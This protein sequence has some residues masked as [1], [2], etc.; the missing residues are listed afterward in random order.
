MKFVSPNGAIIAR[1]SAGL[2]GSVSFLVLA[3]VSSAFA[4]QA[5]PVQPIAAPT[6]NAI[7]L[8][9]TPANEGAV[10]PA[11][12]AQ[13]IQQLPESVL[14]TGSLIHGAPAIGVPVTSFSND[15]FKQ[16]GALTIGNLLGTVAAVYEL[17]QNDVTAGGGFLARGQDVNIRNLTLHG[18]RQLL[19]I[20]GIQ[21]PQQGRGG[22]Q[23]DPSII[24]QLAVDHVDLLVD[25]ASATYGSAA[26]TGVINVIL[27]RAYDGA[28]TQVQFGGSTDLGHYQEQATQLYGRTWDGGDITVSY[29]WYEQQ[30]TS[31][32]VR[33]YFTANY[34]TYAGVDNR[35]ALINSDPGIIS[36]GNP[37]APANTPTGFLATIGTICTNCYAIPKGQNGAGLTWAQILGNNP[38]STSF[39]GNERNLWLDAWTEPNQQRNAI[40]LTFD[41]KVVDSVSFFADAWYDNRQALMFGENS[42]NSISIAVPA[43]NPYYPA[44]APAGIKVNY[45]FNPEFLALGGN[46][47]PDRVSSQEIDG[48]F[49]AGFNINLPFDWIGKLYG[50]QTLNHNLDD[51]TNTINSNMVTAALGGTVAA[52]P[53]SV[54][55]P[56]A[57][58]SFTKPSSVPY[59]N[60]FCDPLAYTCNSPA[61]LNYLTGYSRNN[62][63]ETIDEF[64]LNADGPVIDLPTGTIKAAIGFVYQHWGFNSFSN[65]SNATTA[66][67]NNYTIQTG[68]R[69]IYSTF[70]QLDVPVIGK[71]FTLPLVEALTVEASV[72][73]D[74][75]SDFGP[76]TNPK[77]SADWTV[78]WGLTLRGSYGTSFRAPTFQ[79]EA[80]S[81]PG[82]INITANG[83]LAGSIQTCPTGAAT[84]LS[85]TAAASIAPTC[86][87]YLAGISS[88]FNP[89]IRANGG[90]LSAE[91]AIN[92]SVGFEFTPTYSFLKGLDV[93]ATYWY[94]AMNNIVENYYG[95]AGLQSGELDNP[96]WTHTFLFPGND[97][98][99]ASDVATL[100][101]GPKST[102][103]PAL[104][105]LIQF[106]ADTGNNNIGSQTVNGVDFSASYD[107]DAGDYGAW[108]TGISGTY[109][110]DNKSQGGPGQ[111][112]N[113][114]FHTPQ[115][116][117]STAL[118]TGGRMRYRA[119]L[120]WAN[121]DG[122]SL[123]GFLNFLP[124]FNSDTA[125]LPPSCFVQGNPV[126]ASYGPQFAQYTNQ[127]PR[128]S[129][130]VPG[131]YTFD[132][133]IGYN[134]G[135]KPENS[136]LK[137][138]NFQL[139]IINILDKQAPYAYQINPPGGA[140]IHAYYTTTPGQGFQPLGIDGRTI[141]ATI[142]KQW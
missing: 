91:T 52:V 123:T 118:D 68:R 25:G 41:Q 133:S 114:L 83:T 141:M 70:L 117:N 26:V 137:N 101:N 139:N 127:F 122:L 53:A 32:G 65:A 110:I 97:P 9:A 129:N 67:I 119:R 47:R 87:Q 66:A 49:D 33:P 6:T 19:L 135:E 100:L 20:D 136:Y 69:N 35:M 115:N 34:N 82:L 71:D 107:Y 131:L 28:I 43:N 116:S 56:F 5:L 64:G 86:A 112:V 54:A 50:A 106:I 81:G 75:Y 85:G 46:N 4:Q 126:C 3:S 92:R 42:G 44:G 79:E 22:C 14:V 29:E 132:L 96:I 51:T 138:V 23:T 80:P 103:S 58:G 105:P 142:S 24:P 134:T 11:Q 104:A 77:I 31:G 124:H 27:K 111:V 39:A 62:E 93:Q 72:R 74:H 16:T 95:V 2:L 99:F 40:T 61:T 113:S 1:K 108:N 38:S 125:V 121:D 63:T 84:A 76:T 45:D 89:A 8:A 59:L 48:R 88:G 60:L 98:H 30:H 10:A 102:L 120:G 78:G 37:A 13:A 109:N 21:F 18:P 130:L 7:V 140:Q 128:L 73:Y 12:T 55:Q 36:L 57:I 15:D 94:I 90:N 17:T